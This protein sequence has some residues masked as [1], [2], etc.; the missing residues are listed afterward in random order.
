[1]SGSVLIRG[2][3]I[4]DP[5]QGVDAVGDLLVRDGRVA[6][7]APGGGLSA[8][9][10]TPELDATGLVVTPG[11]IDL[12]CHL[13]EPGYEEKETIATGTLAA[14]RGGF[15]TVCCMPNTKPAIDTRATADFVLGKARHEAAVRVLPIGAVTVD[16]AGRE[17]V[18]M[19]EMTEAGVVAFSDDGS[20]VADARLMRSAL[21][22]ART[23]G[24]P[25]IN[26][27]EEP[28]LSRSGVMH[29]GRVA[30]FLGLGGV[31]AA[32]EDTM[33]ARDIFL[34]ELTGGHVHIAHVSTRGAVELVRQARERGLPVTAEVSPHHLLLTDEAVAGG[35]LAEGRHDGSSGT[36]YDTNAKVNPP[37]RSREHVDAVVAGLRDGVI[38]AIA[39]DHA[40]HTVVDKLC[41]FDLAA[42][43]ISGLE[44]ALG[45]VLALVHDGRITLPALVER[46][47]WGPARIIDGGRTGI[48]TLRAEAPGDVVLFDPDREWVVDAQA[49][50]S[51]GKNTPLDGRRLKGRVV[52]T[53]V[54][55]SVVWAEGERVGAHG[56]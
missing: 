18:E 51:K 17:L 45:S 38:E 22:Y 31:P 11:F 29:E 36:A 3:R 24:V 27:C 48:G 50:A 13:R 10:R 15:T 21:T 30:T 43:G 41:E 33:V 14:A 6:A 37:L 4:I 35:A 40:P 9:E 42:F 23:L 25:I 46:L 12:H 7:V 52:T 8:P 5:A 2:G 49:F 1:M 55:G 47:T 20:P 54:G 32:A 19:G 53:I 39:T 34:A 26:H 44:T 28:G 16:R 56:R